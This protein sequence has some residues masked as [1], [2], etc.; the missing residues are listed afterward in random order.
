MKM[1]PR[2]MRPSLGSEDGSI[3]LGPSNERGIINR[4]LALMRESRKRLA[5]ERI[6]TLNHFACES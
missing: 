6:S 5:H 4:G 2:L 1:A 3:T